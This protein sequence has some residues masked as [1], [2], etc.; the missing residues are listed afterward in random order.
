MVNLTY[1]DYFVDIFSLNLAS[2]I[3]WVTGLVS[4]IFIKKER[5]SQ[6]VGIASL[7]IM[8]LFLF[9]KGKGYYILGLIP[10]LF[11]FGGYIL[12]KYLKDRFVYTNYFILLIT[13]S[14]S[15]AA[16][17]F[18]LPLLSFE[19]LSRYIAKTDHLIIYP[20]YR[21]EDGKI[22]N[23]S[24][25]Y[26]DMTGWKELAGIAGKAYSGLS[27]EEQSRCTIYVESNYGNAAAINFYGKKYNLPDAV[28]FLESYVIWAPDTI[29]NGPFIYINRERGD[30][31]KLFKNV[32]KVGTVN[33]SYFRE[34]GLLVYLCNDPA[35][36][37]QEVYRQ[38][39]IEEKKRYRR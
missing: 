25:V 19:K 13:L 6:Y 23:I 22:H 4:L 9:S 17:P 31:D 27:K 2:T 32:V 10:F 28:T 12:E 26:S 7:L 1:T 5:K 37:V 14:I 8:L 39:A 34:N 24:Q 30:I 20:F 35:V 18:G 11:A 3:I 16:L 15:L 33:N 38:K 21:W 36:N 29:P